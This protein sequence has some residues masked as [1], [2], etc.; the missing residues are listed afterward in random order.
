M[1]HPTTITWILIA[2]GLITCLPLLYA[3][4]ALLIDPEGNKAKNF[5]I[6]EGEEWRDKTHFKFA[7]AAA[8]SDWLIFAPLFVS[9]II[10]ML[11]SKQWGFLFF[12]VSG[13]I[14]VYINTLLWFL[15]KEFVYPSR[16][17]L[18]Y[19]TYYWG[20]FI[21]WGFASFL[22]GVFRLSGYTL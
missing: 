2:F 9:G 4:R 10:R 14:Q 16:G 21:Y 19:Y 18:K 17:P 20:S 5:L 6:G 8:W 12:A 11:L 22:Y 15:E 13:A 7:Y 3:Q 1:Y